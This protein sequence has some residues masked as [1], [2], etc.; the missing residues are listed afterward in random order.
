LWPHYAAPAGFWQQ[1]SLLKSSFE[2]GDG[3]VGA[4]NESGPSLKRQKE[5]IRYASCDPVR[6]LHLFLGCGQIAL[7][8]RNTNLD[9]MPAE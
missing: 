9:H 3:M 2:H 1:L 5:S 4:P 8:N 6:V 7:F